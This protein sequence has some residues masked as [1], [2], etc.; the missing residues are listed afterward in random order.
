MPAAKRI[1]RLDLTDPVFDGIFTLAAQ[2]Y[3]GQVSGAAMITR[4]LIM[5][6]IG[7]NVEQATRAT[8][9]RL[10]YLDALITARNHVGKAMI[11]LGRKLEADGV[12]AE[13]QRLAED[14][15]R[16]EDL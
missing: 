15:H 3:P 5:Q 16:S 2:T 6:S 9:R 12:L 13:A 10:A 4:E 11:E 14:P 7:F 8:S 1:I